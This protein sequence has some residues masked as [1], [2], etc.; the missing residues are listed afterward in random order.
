M[1]NLHITISF[2]KFGRNLIVAGNHALINELFYSPHL[3]KKNERG[4]LM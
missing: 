4:Q 2:S 1:K 3:N